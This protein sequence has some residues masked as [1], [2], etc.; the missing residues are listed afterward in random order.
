MQINIYINKKALYTILQPNAYL[1]VYM[2]IFLSPQ[3][4]YKNYENFCI[5][6]WLYLEIQ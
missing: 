3:E 2:F 4:Y 5:S 1:I 6:T